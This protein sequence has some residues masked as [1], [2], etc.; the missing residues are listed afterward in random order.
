MAKLFKPFVEDQLA[1]WAGNT[2][3]L[4]AHPLSVS[5]TEQNTKPCYI[6]PLPNSQPTTLALGPEG[7]FSSYEVR[8]ITEQGFTRI[9]LGE[10]ILRVETA[11]PVAIAQL[12]KL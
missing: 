7:G 6:A 5:A 3:C 9:S 4:I 1:H 8:K 11:I 10:R 2:R 12:M